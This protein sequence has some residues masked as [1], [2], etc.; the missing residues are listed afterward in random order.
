MSTRP[1]PVE[2]EPG[3]VN[4]QLTRTLAE[5][6]HGTTGRAG[7]PKPELRMPAIGELA[8]VEPEAPWVAEVEWLPDAQAFVD[9]LP[10]VTAESVA[11]VVVGAEPVLEPEPVADIAAEAAPVAEPV[12]A[13]EPIADAAALSEPELAAATLNTV[14]EPDGLFDRAWDVLYTL[15]AT[16]DAAEED[17]SAVDWAALGPNAR[18]LN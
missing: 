16:A 4:A 3:S 5:L 12:A 17:P 8:P 1:R 7:G 2:A 13:A 11:E 6:D 14:A 9:E 15:P 18:P 10:V